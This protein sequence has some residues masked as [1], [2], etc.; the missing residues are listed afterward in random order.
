[1]NCQG[2]AAA[3][4]GTEAAYS[5]APA[6]LESGAV[7]PTNFLGLH[8]KGT[9]EQRHKGDWRFSVPALG[10]IKLA[11]GRSP[12]SPR[13]PAAVLHDNLYFPLCL[14]ALGI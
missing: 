7:L 13:A 6:V 1:M 9:K 11:A 5:R 2:A 12:A 10:G 4:E 8:P 3:A 14:C